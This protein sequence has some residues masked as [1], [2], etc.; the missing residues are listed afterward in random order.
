MENNRCGLV[1][2]ILEGWVK[3]RT[4]NVEGNEMTLNIVDRGKIIREMAALE[5]ISRSTDTVTLR[6]TTVSS[7]PTQKFISLFHSNP[8][9]GIGIR[10]PQVM[11]KRLHRLNRRLRVCSA[12][13]SSR[14][15]DALLFLADGRGETTKHSIE[16][17]DLP[18][19]EL[20]SISDLARE[21]IKCSLT[22]L[23]KKV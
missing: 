16:I 23:E 8:V 11:A 2:F 9:I 1:Y 4:H 22:K 15:A 5:E 18:H 10:F 12:Y 21:T 3:I 20:S 19:R 13:S 6:P 17:S 7:I 14:A